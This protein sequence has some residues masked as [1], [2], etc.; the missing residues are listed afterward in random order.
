MR[1]SEISRKTY[2]TDIHLKLNIDGSGNGSISTGIGFFDHMLDLFTRHGLFDLALKAVG[3]L[4]VDFHHTVEDVGL[5][6][7][8][9]FK[10]AIGDKYGINRYGFSSLPM[11][12]TLVNVSVDVSGRPI[13]NLVNPLENRSAGD[14]P[15]D[16][17][18]VFFQAF[19]GQG[20]ITAHAFLITGSDPHHA[21]E[22]FFKGFGRALREALEKDARV[23][24]IPS[25]KGSLD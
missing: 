24:G 7:G 1:T 14:F 19:S 3:D 10:Q 8:A 4:H 5:C 21:A 20:G 12:E 25:T 18:K 16:L 6:L 17:V 9:A 13:L 23:Q 15:L 2:E 22:A 11:D